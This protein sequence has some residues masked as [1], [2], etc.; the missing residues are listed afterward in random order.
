MTAPKTRRGGGVP[1]LRP[2]LERWRRHPVTAALERSSKAERAEIVVVGEP[3]RAAWLAGLPEIVGRPVAAVLP[4]A[5]DVERTSNDVTAFRGLPCVIDAWETL[6]YEHVSPS[7]ETMGR[8]LAAFRSLQSKSP[9]ALTLFGVRALLQRVS[10]TAAR[11][12]AIELTKSD[13]LDLESFERRLAAFGYERTYLVEARGDFA[14]RGGIVDIYPSTGSDPLRVEF[15]GD[16]I[17]TIRRFSVGDQRSI[18]ETQS[19]EILPCRELMIDEAVR[20]RA[21]VVGARVANASEALGRI[22]RGETFAGMESWLPWLLED[23]AGSLLDQFPRDCLV[24]ICEPKRSFDRAMDLRREEEDLATALAR[25]W[26]LPHAGLLTAV[27]LREDDDVP[28]V[29]EPNGE[30]DPVESAE[31]EDLPRLFL[32]A[33]SA[34]A[35]HKGLVWQVPSVAADPGLLEI[36]AGAPESI[37]GQPDVLVRRLA[38][39]ASSGKTVVVAADGTGSRSRIRDNLANEGFALQVSEG[40]LRT[41][42]DHATVVAAPLSRGFISGELGLALFAESDLTGR[43]RARPRAAPRKARRDADQAEIYG[44]LHSGDFVVHYVHGIGRFDG[45]VSRGIGGVEREYLELSYS[46]HDKLYVPVDQVDAVRKYIGGETPRLS[47]MGGSDWSRTKSKVR[48]AVAEIADELVTLY[49]NR[50]TAPGHEFPVDGEFSFALAES[51][52]FEETP[53]QHRAIRDVAADMESSFPMDRLICGDVGYGK[54]E[55]AVRASMKAV[56]GGKQVAVL[57]PTTVLA[58]QHFQ[59]FSER[60]ADLPVRVEVISR[61]L[62]TAE[63]RRVTAA[64]T[65]GDVDIVIGTHRLLQRDV[66]IPR[67][68]LLI[69]DEEQRFG[70][71]AKERLKELRTHI[72]VLTMTATPIPR[73]LEFG[74]T[75]IRDMSTVNTPPEDR[76][77]VLTYV[78]EFD[79]QSVAAAIRRELLRDGQVFYV[80]NRVRSIDRVAA[81]L[82]RMVPEARIGVA[83]GQLDDSTLER[84]MLSFWDGEFDVLVAT[85]IIE[86][87]LDI[88]RAN[89]LIVDRADML[90]L[91][92]LYQLRGR[93][94]RSRDRAYAYLFYP[95]DRALSEEAHERLKV[96]AEHQDL[97]SGIAIAMRDLELRGA[98]NLLGGAQSGHIAAVGF[99]LYCQLVSEAVAA[100]KGEEVVE[101]VHARVDLP[102]EAYLPATY[103]PKESLRLEAYR[104][105]GDASTPEAIADVCDEWTDRYGAPP[106]VAENLLQLARVKASALRVGVREVVFSRGQV[107]L[108]PAAPKGSRRMRLERLNPG[109]IFKVDPDQVLVPYRDPRSAGRGAGARVGPPGLAIAEW[110]VS[111][112]EDLAA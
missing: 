99:D 77:P 38:D 52:E 83:H 17:D 50:L 2:L 16:E 18:D 12:S 111:V 13:E 86:S 33:Q 79:E 3:I 90:G 71:K 43:R 109:T 112:L 89:T 98:G 15:W 6:P 70:V 67:L 63:Q 75:G 46:G 107:R 24:L 32:D 84:M 57:V 54:T 60:F 87:G 88:S 108:A 4:T 11:V 62:T 22:S 23:G 30:S 104:R 94:G 96:I 58:Q 14:V 40:P 45:V 74:L 8:R 91:A 72:D 103:V 92:Q 64:L 95:A 102:V 26:R 101:V 110:V 51:F 35:E 69:V 1:P 56:S 42:P 73:T 61:F 28:E 36:N 29:A 106:E 41:D 25:T 76:Q 5:A 44:D 10:P 19:V 100:L 39:L 49:R 55:I 68:G 9:P 65:A 37:F 66:D 31:A 97:G 82:R 21:R 59:T 7:I 93:V 81:E 80:H 53:D 47:R 105:L 78:G 27:S 85:T 34:L 48:S 20:E